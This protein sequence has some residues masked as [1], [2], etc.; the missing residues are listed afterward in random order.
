MDVWRLRTRQISRWGTDGEIGVDDVVLLVLLVRAFVAR[1]DDGWVRRSEMC[2][3][4]SGGPG[5]LEGVSSMLLIVV[6][7]EVDAGW[8]W[9]GGRFFWYRPTRV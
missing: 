8:V 5:D 9:V 7:G 1:E 6:D 2:G 4:E 3:G